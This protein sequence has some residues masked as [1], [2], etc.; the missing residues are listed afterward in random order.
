MEAMQIFLKCCAAQTDSALLSSLRSALELKLPKHTSDRSL[1]LSKKG[2]I[3]SEVYAL[4]L[5]VACVAVLCL[6]TFNRHHN[7][8]AILV[9][10]NVV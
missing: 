1:Q 2:W 6:A 10:N 4:S 9:Q 8:I 7:C 3:S 5:A